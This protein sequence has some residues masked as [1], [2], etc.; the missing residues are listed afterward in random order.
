MAK[1]TSYGI[2][3]FLWEIIFKGGATRAAAAVDLEAMEEGQ[4]KAG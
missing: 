2:C 3:I 4:E 1:E